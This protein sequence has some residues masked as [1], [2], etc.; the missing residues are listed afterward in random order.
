MMVSEMSRLLRPD[1]LSS[2][3]ILDHFKRAGAL[4]NVGGSIVVFSSPEGF[5]KSK[6]P[7]CN[8]PWNRIEA[9]EELTLAFVKEMLSDE[10]LVAEIISES[11]RGARDTV[12]SFPLGGSDIEKQLDQVKRRERR[13]MDAYEGGSIDLDELKARKG[14]LSEE[15][16]RIRR[17]ADAQRGAEDDTTEKEGLEAVKFVAEGAKALDA[18]TTDAER[19]KLIKSLFLKIHFRGESITAF[20]LA[21]ELLPANG[22][23]IVSWNRKRTCLA[24]PEEVL[25]AGTK[26]CTKCGEVKLV[27]DFHRKH[28]DRGDGAENRVTGCK[29]C[30]KCKNAVRHQRRKAAGQG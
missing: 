9:Q 10:E 16:S 27:D 24:S 6:L 29:K 28:K 1:D 15:R 8:Q 5:P 19:K 18:S 25:P 20:T 14:K 12:S 17:L 7:R 23:A 4:I 11:E 26:M 2:L 22:G 3:G 13:L 21:P 30:K